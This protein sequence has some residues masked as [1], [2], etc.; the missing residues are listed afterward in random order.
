MKGSSGPGNWGEKV[1][2]DFSALRRG[3]VSEDGDERPEWLVQE[4]L[5]QNRRRHSITLGDRGQF[6]RKQ[7]YTIDSTHSLQV[8]FSKHQRRKMLPPYS[9]LHL[10]LIV[11]I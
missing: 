2:D 4:L 8:Q 3:S 6:M 7:Q 1:T 10:K 5:K 11:L 9:S